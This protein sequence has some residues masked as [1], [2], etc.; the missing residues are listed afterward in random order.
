M[1]QILKQCEE[2]KLNKYTAQYQFKCSYMILFSFHKVPKHTHH[3]SSLVTLKQGVGHTQQRSAVT[4]QA[5]QQQEQ[6]SSFRD[7]D[8]FPGEMFSRTPTASHNHSGTGDV[9]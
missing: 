5:Q 4:A 2:K 1:T 7:L 9:V 3:T 6:I 8:Y